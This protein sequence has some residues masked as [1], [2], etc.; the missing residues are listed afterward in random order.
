MLLSIHMTMVVKIALESRPSTHWISVLLD[1]KAS[2]TQTAR[3]N[4]KRLRQ[5]LLL[6]NQKARILFRFVLDSI[7]P[8]TL[9]V[10]WPLLLYHKL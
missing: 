5:T 4:A 3:D 8:G 2:I 7:N 10:S 9:F 6:R 1:S